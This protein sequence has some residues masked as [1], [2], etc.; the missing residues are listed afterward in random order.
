MNLPYKSKYCSR[1]VSGS[2]Y[3][4]IKCIEEVFIKALIYDS[5]DLFKRYKMHYS[6]P[7]NTNDL[8]QQSLINDPKIGINQ[9]DH[10]SYIF[11]TQLLR[12]SFTT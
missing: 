4:G 5:V 10:L 1:Q 3:C 12:A 6:Q 9:Q 7:L 2:A 11:D 8:Y